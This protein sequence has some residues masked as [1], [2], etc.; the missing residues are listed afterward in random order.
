MLRRLLYCYRYVAFV[1]GDGDNINFMK[2]SRR[3]WFLDRVQRCQADPSYKGCFPLLWSASPQLLHLAPDWLRW[4]YEQA[5]LTKRDYF[6]LPP[7]GDLYRYGLVCLLSP[8]S[9]VW[10]G[11]VLLHAVAAIRNGLFAYNR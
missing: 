4:Y 10:P 2:G 9:R 3:D 1:I 8:S 7:S 11:Y 5:R 6:V